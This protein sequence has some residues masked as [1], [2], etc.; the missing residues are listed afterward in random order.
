MDVR[1]D[2]DGVA[3]GATTAA[4]AVGSVVVVPSSPLLS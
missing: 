2:G 4:I 1:G 3:T